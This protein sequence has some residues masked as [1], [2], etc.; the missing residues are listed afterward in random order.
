[1]HKSHT[2]LHNIVLDAF[3][4][5]ASRKKKTVDKIK[6]QMFI[7]EDEKEMRR[8]WAIIDNRLPNHSYEF[9]GCCAEC[10]EFELRKEP[11]ETES[12]DCG[13]DHSLFLSE[14]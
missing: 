11:P 1:M 6:K 12:C 5:L 4:T 7:H 13:V 10:G 8:F 2:D 9:V 14:W 3:S